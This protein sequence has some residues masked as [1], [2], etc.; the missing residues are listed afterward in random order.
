MDDFLINTIGPIIDQNFIFMRIPKRG[1]ART[2]IGFVPLQFLVEDKAHHGAV[3][4]LD[5]VAVF[6]IFA[7]LRGFALEEIEPVG[8]DQV[9]D[10]GPAE[11]ARGG[12][13]RQQD[14]DVFFGEGLQ[15]GRT[16]RGVRRGGDVGLPVVVGGTGGGGYATHVFLFLFGFLLSF[17]FVYF[18]FRDG[19]RLDAWEMEMRAADWCC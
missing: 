11:R 15:G 18:A 14:V 16:V 13:G 10:G 6:E 12:V 4:L 9:A 7:Q 5:G 19:G 1:I 8:A 2:Q 17:L 3:G